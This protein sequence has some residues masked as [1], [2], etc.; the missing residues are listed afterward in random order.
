F[1]KNYEK[2]RGG[3]RGSQPPR[4][5]QKITIKHILNKG[6]TTVSPR[7]INFVL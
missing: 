3:Q 1:T 4:A 5:K 2:H 7:L 6:E